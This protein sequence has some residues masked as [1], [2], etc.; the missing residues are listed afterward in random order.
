[1]LAE[2]GADTEAFIHVCLPACLSFCL[3]HSCVCRFLPYWLA[4]LEGGVSL[5][6]QG[7]MGL[8]EQPA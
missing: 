8:S 5:I 2:E 6:P 1:M 4:A 7:L 3:C